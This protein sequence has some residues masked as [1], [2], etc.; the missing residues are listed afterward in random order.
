MRLDRFDLNLLI[1]LDILLEE[2]NVTRASERL[3]IGQSATSAALGRLRDYFG[4]NLLVPV[5]RRMELTPLAQ[6]LAAPVRDTLM[7]AR[8]TIA[9]RPNFDPA[10]MSRDFSIAASDYMVEVLVARAVRSLAKSTPGLRLDLSSL[11]NDLMEAFERGAIDLLF[12]PEQ[13]AS[14]LQHPQVELMRDDQ[15]CMMCQDADIDELTMEQYLDRGHIAIRLGDESSLAFEEWF[16]PRFGRQ[17]RIECTVDHFSAAPLLVMGTDRIVTL[18]R[19]LAEQMAQRFP[20]KLL[21]APFD[22]QPVV[23]VMVWPHYLDED[24][25]HKWLRST[26]QSIAC[27]LTGTTETGSQP[28]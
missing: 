9:L 13:Y 19:R 7:R 1:V 3:H 6:S 14:R 25:A 15:V 17:R 26:V 23:E 10:T 12:I 20:V 21:E 28:S 11:P 22:M 2:R 24:P 27:S 4:D 18:H 5:G 8:A 16:L